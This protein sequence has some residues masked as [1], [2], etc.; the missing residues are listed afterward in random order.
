MYVYQFIQK[1][2]KGEVYLRWCSHFLY[3]LVQ[4][5]RF[6]SQNRDD[7]LQIKIDKN[8]RNL[9]SDVLLDLFCHENLQVCIKFI[10]FHAN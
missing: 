3:N 10:D 5:S 6:F 2:K 9:T 7:C 4:S 8:A 1:V